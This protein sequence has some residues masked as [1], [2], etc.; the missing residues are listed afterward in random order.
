VRLRII[1]CPRYPYPTMFGSEEKTS[2]LKPVLILLALLTLGGA[3]FW[4]MSTR[5]SAA[6]SVPKVQLYA[7]HTTTA[8]AAGGGHIVGQVAES[9]DDLYVAVTL[10]LKN[11]LSLPLFIDTVAATYTDAT[12]AT[13]DTRALGHIDLARTE[14]IFPALTPLTP[15]PFPLNLAIP[16]GATTEGTI[17]LH[18]PGLTEQTWKARKSAVLTLNFTHQPPQTVTIP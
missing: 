4:F 13:M 6:L 7:A 14:D 11:N 16:A 17:L 3:A 1:A 8:A 18:F 2:P 15:N 12:D 10:H 5:Q 9:G